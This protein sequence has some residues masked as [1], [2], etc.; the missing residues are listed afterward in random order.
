MEQLGQLMRDRR[1]TLG[2]TQEAVARKMDVSTRQLMRWESG[3]AIPNITNLAQW[4]RVLGVQYKDVE[5]ILLRN[6]IELSK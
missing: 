5:A 6:H 4:L 3:E 2:F 1:A